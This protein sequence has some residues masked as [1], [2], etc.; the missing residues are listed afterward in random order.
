MI[1]IAINTFG[2]ATYL[3]KAQFQKIKKPNFM[4]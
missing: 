3:A 4:I 1:Y 2:D